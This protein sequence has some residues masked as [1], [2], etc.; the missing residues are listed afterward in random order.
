[1]KIQK[2]LLTSYCIT[3]LR[4]LAHLNSLRISDGVLIVLGYVE[5]ISI[6]RM[7]MKNKVKPVL[8]V[9][10][11]DRAILE[12]REDKQKMVSL[13]GYLQDDIDDLLLQLEQRT[14]SFIQ[15]RKGSLASNMHQIC[16]IIYIKIQYRILE[17]I[18][19]V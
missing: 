19:I 14:V 4:F 12:L 17:F 10:K 8:M 5:G 6:L 7:V 2:K 1:M 3:Q 15:I 13:F 9:D 16:Y 18:R 11:L